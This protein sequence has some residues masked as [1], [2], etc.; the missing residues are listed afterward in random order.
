LFEANETD[1]MSDSKAEIWTNWDDFVAKANVLQV[2]AEGAVIT[3]QASIG[4]A[5]GAMGKTCGACHK[6]Y[7]N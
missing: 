4:A 5:L 3:D 7:R 2:A 6:V 1:P